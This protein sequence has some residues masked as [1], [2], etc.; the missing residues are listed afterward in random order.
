VKASARTAADSGRAKCSSC[1]L[2]S[3]ASSITCRRCGSDLST[4]D[5]H[6]AAPPPAD[7][8]GRTPGQW[9][10]W[11]AGVVAAI[12]VAAYASLLLTSAGLTPPQRQTIDA[13]IAVIDGAGL[14]REA[15]TL[16]RLVTYRGSDNWWNRYVGHHPAYAATNYPFAVVTV[17]PQFFKYP[18]DDVERAAILLHEA[19]HVLGADEETALRR[20]WMEKGRLGWNAAE[21]GNTRVWKNTRE[22]TTVGA[23]ALF[24]C[25]LDDAS[26]CVR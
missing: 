3:F 11:I 19:K 1:G 26:D 9:L 10:I 25:G 22:W 23:P 24:K 4:D 12:V 16:R 13:A 17:Y 6:Q 5:R 15:W 8:G 21:Y 7:A 2:V 14:S 18:V 20:V